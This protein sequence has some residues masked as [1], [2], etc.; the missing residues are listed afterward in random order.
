MLRLSEALAGVKKFM[1][2][3]ALTIEFDPQAGTVF[4]VNGKQTGETIPG[5][6]VFG[7]AMHIWLGSD[8]ADWKLK[9]LLLGK[10]SE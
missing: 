3:D 7:G 6:I 5:A 2:G 10:T 4:K 8:P 9:D 1:P